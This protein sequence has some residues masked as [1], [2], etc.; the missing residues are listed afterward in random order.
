MKLLTFDTSMGK[1]SVA[2][3]DNKL[4]DYQE[5]KEKL[6]QS[7]ELLPMI[8]DIL[9]KHDSKLANIHAIACTIGPGS[10]TGIRIGIAAARGIKKILPQLKLLGISTLEILAYYGKTQNSSNKNI[11]VF[12]NAY[13]NEF[14]LQ[15]FSNNLT[16]V[17]EIKLV[18]SKKIKETVDKNDILVSNNKIRDM[19]CSC[20]VT[21]TNATLLLEY[22]KKLLYTNVCHTS[23]YPLYI[24]SP[25][26]TI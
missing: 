12:V 24:K 21:E 16:P 3:S 22:S 7:E 5:S 11:T 9:A 1:C 15:R 25:N 26:I 23:I 10:F 19:H 6:M 17:S 14:Y 20:Y 8:I 2:F 18:N 4:K 13:K